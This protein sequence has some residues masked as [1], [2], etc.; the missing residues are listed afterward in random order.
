MNDTIKAQERT[1]SDEVLNIDEM[2]SY[3]KIG[4]SNVYKLL[5]SGKIRSFRIGRKWLATKGEIER[6]IGNEITNSEQ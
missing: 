2:I 3:L 5:R 1:P 4:R 6:Y